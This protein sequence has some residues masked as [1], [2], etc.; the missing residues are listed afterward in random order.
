MSKA[1]NWRGEAR[2]EDPT[3]IYTTWSPEDDETTSPRWSFGKLQERRIITTTHHQSL[4][5]HLECL[6]LLFPCVCMPWLWA[7]PAKPQGHRMP[8]NLGVNLL[9]GWCLFDLIHSLGFM[10]LSMW[11]LLAWMTWELCIHCI[12]FVLVGARCVLVL[13]PHREVG[14]HM[15]VMSTALQ[16]FGSKLV[17]DVFISRLEFS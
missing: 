17:G 3:S 6:S 8:V 14:L 11:F 15:S 9:F 10:H 7:C 5:E 13:D 16:Q 12:W 1:W 4:R 2:F